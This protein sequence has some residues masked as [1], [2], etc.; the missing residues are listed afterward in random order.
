MYIEFLSDVEQRAI[1]R[2]QRKLPVNI[3]YLAKLFEI[4]ISYKLLENDGYIFHN[5]RDDSFKIVVNILNSKK[6]QR[7][8]IAHELA[9]F[10]FHKSQIILQEILEHGVMSEYDDYRENEA[11]KLAA[12]IL[13]PIKKVIPMIDAGE[14]KTPEELSDRL[15]VP[16][17]ALKIKLQ[18][19]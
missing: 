7:F 1:K 4:S 6:K 18:L 3:N 15:L 2:A 12:E 8:T 11:N 5:K 19:K 9:H 10:L 14:F 13:I 16:R 17:E